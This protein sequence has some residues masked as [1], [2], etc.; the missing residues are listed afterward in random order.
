MSQCTSEFHGRLRTDLLSGTQETL[1][2]NPGKSGWEVSWGRRRKKEYST[3][4]DNIL[5]RHAITWT[6]F[7]KIVG[8]KPGMSDNYQMK[9]CM[10]YL[11]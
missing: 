3:L 8:N 9:H 6:N 11:V 2:L 5:L 10:K 7:E 4:E 1:W